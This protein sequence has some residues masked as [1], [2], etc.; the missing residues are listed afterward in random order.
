MYQTVYIVIKSNPS[1]AKSKKPGF[2]NSLL[3]PVSFFANDPFDVTFYKV[4]VGK[5]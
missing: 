5:L 4:N 3:T 1:Q 2:C